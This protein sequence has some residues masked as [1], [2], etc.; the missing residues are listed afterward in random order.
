MASPPCEEATRDALKYGK[1]L[2]KFLSPNDCGATGT[3]QAGYLLPKRGEVWTLFTPDAPEK[4]VIKKHDVRVQWPDGRVTESVVTWYGQ[5]TRSEYRLTKFGRDFPWRDPDLVGAL[6]V[7]IPK[8]QTEFNAYVLEL[9]DDI[10]DIQTALGVQVVGR[11]AVFDATQ[12]QTEETEDECVE[13]LFRDFAGAA[14]ELPTGKVLSSKAR[15]SLR[16]CIAGLRAKPLDE[17]L[18]EWVRAEYRLF[19]MMERHVFQPK[20]TKLFASL[21]EFL[22]TAMSIVQARKSRAGRSLE[23]HV[24]YL[25]RESSIPFEVRVR[26]DGTVPDI[27]IP[28]KAA[29]EDEAFPE[30]KLVVM[31]VKTTCKDRWRQVLSEAPRIRKKHI[32]TIQE[33]ISSRQLDEMH[34]SKVALVVPKP[35]HDRYPAGGSVTMYDVEAFIIFL[36]SLLS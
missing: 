6:F 25:L 23:N 29:Y 3:H 30:R 26:V 22:K 33:G 34:R 10:E 16:D 36:R 17:Q 31:G 19:K 7:L 13:R 20:V 8:T 11:W 14:E 15:D 21:D 32:L 4:G 35:L 1:A 12:E 18:L 5:E 2:L 9:E 24:E 27:L 28:G